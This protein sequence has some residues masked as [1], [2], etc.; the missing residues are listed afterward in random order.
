MP[1]P[2]NEG[3]G[4]HPRNPYSI[5]VRNTYIRVRSMKAGAF[6]PA[7]PAAR[8]PCRVSAARSL[9]EGGG[10][11]PRNPYSINVRTTYIP[12]R[13]MKAGAFTPA[14]PGLLADVYH[15]ETHAQ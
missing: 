1:R 2:L 3:G 9:N 5:N 15:I 6:T 7:I 10:F 11:H 14:I 12:M 13:S 8:T 4:F